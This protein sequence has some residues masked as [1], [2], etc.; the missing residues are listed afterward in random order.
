MGMGWEVASEGANARIE[1]ETLHSLLVLALLVHLSD[2]LFA[3]LLVAALFFLMYPF[4]PRTNNNNSSS[5]HTV[6]AGRR[7]VAPRNSLVADRSSLV[8]TGPVVADRAS[9]C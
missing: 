7:A 2:L 4:L 1:R 6:L 9:R 5:P 3:E 8:V